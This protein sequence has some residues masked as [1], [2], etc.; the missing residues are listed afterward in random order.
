MTTS[1]DAQRRHR[2]TDRHDGGA[3]QGGR[4]QTDRRSMMTLGDLCD[5]VDGRV[6]LVLEMKSI[7]LV[8]AGAR[9]A[10]GAGT[11]E[12]SWTG[13]GDVVRS[14]SGDRDP[15]TFAEHD[16]R[17]R[18]P[19]HLQQFLLD[20]SAQKTRDSMSTCATWIPHPAA[21][22]CLL[23]QRAARARAVGSPAICLA[24]RC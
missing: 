6:P 1:S 13:G 16:L 5:L 9:G 23:G 17:H 12:L 19:A 20:P 10:D 15:R 7:Y 3:A 22:R 4:T 14:R 24:A 21:F 8:T 11:C 18:R 2:R